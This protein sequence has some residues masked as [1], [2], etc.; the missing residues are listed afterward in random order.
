MG[1][2]V[3][4]GISKTDIIHFIITHFIDI[5]FLDGHFI[6]LLNGHFIDNSVSL[7]GRSVTI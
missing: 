4:K 5:H 3:D 2:F 7:S 1:H 6:S